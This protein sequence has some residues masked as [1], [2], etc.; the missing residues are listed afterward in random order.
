M[1][2]VESKVAALEKVGVAIARTPA[3]QQAQQA[4]ARDGFAPHTLPYPMPGSLLRGP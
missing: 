4:R 3:G 2:S 1:G